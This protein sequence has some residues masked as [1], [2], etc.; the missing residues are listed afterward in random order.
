MND[1]F[2]L[3]NQVALVTGASR[4]LGWAMAQGLAE[5]GARVILNGRH[6]E[7]LEPRVAEL[8]S[9]KL[10]ADLAPFDVTDEAAVV[11][12]LTQLTRDHGRLAILVNNAGIV[13][14]S[15]LPEAGTEAWREVLDV[16]LTA[17]FVLAR[18][19]S[20]V[21]ARPGRIINIGSILSVVGRGTIPSYVASK[22]GLAG[23]TKALA[24]ELGPLGINVNA[25]CPGYFRTELNVP[26]QQDA[27]FTRRVEEKTPLGRWGESQELKGAVVFLAS[28]ASSYVNGHLLVVDGGMTTT[29]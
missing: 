4:G 6:A 16:N 19:A 2:S 29:L 24:A 20:Q 1:L 15:S 11:Q 28:G 12:A 7:T 22:H 13:H 9:R 8:V 25:L 26:L 5:A 14:R 18:Q 17:P 10:D 23:L 3:V 21:M 27:E